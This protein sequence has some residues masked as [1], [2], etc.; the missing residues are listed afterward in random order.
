M[1]S[2]LFVMSKRI[3]SVNTEVVIFWVRDSAVSCHV[4]NMSVAWCQCSSPAVLR[5][6]LQKIIHKY[7]LVLKST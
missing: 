1:Y 4:K 3:G 6:G 7:T 5:P 2:I